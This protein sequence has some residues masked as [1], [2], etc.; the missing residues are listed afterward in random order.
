M[1]ELVE[2]HIGRR[3][4]IVSVKA[5]VNFVPFVY[6]ETYGA[7]RLVPIQPACNYSRFENWMPHGIPGRP[8]G[9]EGRPIFHLEIIEKFWAFTLH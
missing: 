2:K 6:V 4:Y 8:E 3:V 9:I 1:C 7:T 5:D